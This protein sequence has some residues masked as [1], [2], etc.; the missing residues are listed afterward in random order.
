MP[1]VEDYQPNQAHRTKSSGRSQWTISIS[2]EKTCFYL[3][4][5]NLWILQE[6][7]WGLHYPEGAPEYLGVSEDQATPIFIARFV[8]K[9]GAWH[10]YPAD[11]QK[12]FQDIPDQGILLDWMNRNLLAA[13][14]IRKIVR[15]QS[16]RL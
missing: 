7:G 2:A 10:G 4:I 13:S 16:C 15:G 11:H 8:G 5:E 9:S 3:C 12:N 14:K 6:V 1:S